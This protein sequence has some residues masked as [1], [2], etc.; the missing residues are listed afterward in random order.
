MLILQMDAVA[1]QVFVNAGGDALTQIQ[2]VESILMA[3]H[4]FANRAPLTKFF[5][6]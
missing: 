4:N 3:L 5:N 2:D 6:R 1:R